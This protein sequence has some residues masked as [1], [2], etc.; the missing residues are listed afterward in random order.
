MD[1]T[2]SALLSITMTAAVPSAE[3]SSTSASK[4]IRTVSHTLQE[5]NNNNNN[6]DNLYFISYDLGIS[7][8]DDPPGMTASRLSHPPTHVYMHI[9]INIYCISSLN[10]QILK[11]CNISLCTVHAYTTLPVIVTLTTEQY[12]H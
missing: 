12:D 1:R 7:G 10:S 8:V 5:I 2:T 6:N 4:S 9:V 3:C 11:H